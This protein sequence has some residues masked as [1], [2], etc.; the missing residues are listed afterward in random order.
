MTVTRQKQ[1]FVSSE[2]NENYKGKESCSC[3]FSESDDY[4][5][6]KLLLLLANT[7]ITILVKTRRYVYGSLNFLSCRFR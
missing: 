4:F 6:T 5:F 3:M 1:L 2:A 7:C